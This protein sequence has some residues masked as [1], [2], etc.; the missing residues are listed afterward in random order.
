MAK[1]EEAVLRGKI[2]KQLREDTGLTQKELGKRCGINYRLI[3]S[4]EQGG[5][6]PKNMTVGT[7]FL[8]ARGLNIPINTLVEKLFD[9]QEP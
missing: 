9:Y 4:Y 6:D 2:L 8:L 5:K 7:L 3:Q 1:S